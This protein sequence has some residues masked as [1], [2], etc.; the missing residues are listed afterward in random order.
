MFISIHLYRLTNPAKHC[1]Q[2]KSRRHFYREEERR[3]FATISHTRGGDIDYSDVQLVARLVEVHNLHVQSFLYDPWRDK[4]LFTS[5]DQENNWLIEPVR[6]GTKSR[7]AATS[8]FRHEMQNGHITMFDDRV[9]QAGMTNAVTLVDNNGIKI[10]KNLAIDKIDCLDAII[11]CFYEAMLHFEGVSRDDRAATTRLQVG[12]KTTSIH[13][14][15]ISVFRV[16]TT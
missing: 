11:N 13:F 15:N 3:G 6:Q 5:S 1:Y 14:T 4:S 10:D 2:G 8:F 9:M 7:R 16:V 12:N